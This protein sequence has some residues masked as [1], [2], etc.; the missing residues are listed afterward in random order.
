M[1]QILDTFK[2]SLQNSFKLCRISSFNCFFLVS[3]ILY[4]ISTKEFSHT[5]KF[6]LVWPKNMKNISNEA[7]DTL[8]FKKIINILI[9][10]N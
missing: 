3:V 6:G 10:I 5:H 8:L 2:N 9:T 1:K 4:K 7:K